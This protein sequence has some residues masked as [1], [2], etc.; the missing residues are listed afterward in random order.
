VGFVGVDFR[1]NVP[2]R[3]MSVFILER[4]LSLV[5]TV[6]TLLHNFLLLLDINGVAIF[7]NERNMGI[8]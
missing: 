7:K 2:C 3:H 6:M 4:D 5:N 1:I 8:E